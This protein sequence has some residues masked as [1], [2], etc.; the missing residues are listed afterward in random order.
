[1]QK[2]RKAKNYNKIYITDNLQCSKIAECLSLEDLK[3]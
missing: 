3:T 2:L 1:M